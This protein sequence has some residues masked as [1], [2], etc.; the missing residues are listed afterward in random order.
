MRFG[1]SIALAVAML[2]A[3]TFALADDSSDGRAADWKVYRN[4][5]FGYAIAYPPTLAL[6]AWIDGA[7]GQLKDAR[8]GAALVELELWPSDECPRQKP[9]TTARALGVERA[10]DVTPADG[11][12][13]SSWCG[14]P[15]TVHETRSPH[16]LAVYELTLSCESE[17]SEEDDDE[18]DV[19][20][21]PAPPVH[22]HEGTKGPTFFVD[23]SP[24][25]KARVLVADPVGVDPRFGS[26]KQHIDLA[27]LR[28]ILATVERVP[29]V[30]PDVVCIDEIGPR[31]MTVVRPAASPSPTR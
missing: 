24:A 22:T 6:E 23:V 16:G 5:T 28:K 11:A 17:R 25:W 1:T 8:T 12:G 31:G 10:K 20:P 26:T 15:V 2:V 19:P 9:G 7:S 30:K 27:L 3:A 13:S 29:T 4:E 21:S 18:P 14:E